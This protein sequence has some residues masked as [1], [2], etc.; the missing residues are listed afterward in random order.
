[1]K[2]KI[3]K[4]IESQ[5]KPKRLSEDLEEVNPNLNIENNDW[6]RSVPALPLSSIQDPKSPDTLNF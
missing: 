4:A 3:D 2:E 6:T 1:M 5:A